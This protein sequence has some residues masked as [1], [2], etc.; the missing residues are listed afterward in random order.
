[1]QHPKSWETPYQSRV[2]EE[3]GPKLFIPAMDTGQSQKVRKMCYSLL[4]PMQFCLELYLPDTMKN[5]ISPYL[6]FILKLPYKI[7]FMNKHQAS[8]KAQAVK[9]H[10]LQI[11]NMKLSSQQAL[12]LAPWKDMIQEHAFC[13]PCWLQTRCKPIHAV[14]DLFPSVGTQTVVPMGI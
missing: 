1:M 13:K 12:L 4:C 5:I 9:L 10:Q 14:W 2:G 6:C 8:A 11:T 7:P 3:W